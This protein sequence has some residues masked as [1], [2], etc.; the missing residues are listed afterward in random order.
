MNDLIIVGAGGHALVVWEAAVSMSAFNILGFV[1]PSKAGEELAGLPI[2]EHSPGVENFVVA[3]GDNHARKRIFE[4]YLTLGF[5]PATVIHPTAYVALRTEVGAGT[6]LLAK[7]VINPFAT[8]GKNCII[9]TAAT[10]DHQCSIESHVH[11]SV[12]VHLCGNT[13]VG[14]GALMGVGSITRPSITIGAWST[15][16]AGAVMVCDVE[17]NSTVIGV[18]AKPLHRSLASNRR[19]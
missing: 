6:V 14:E 9:N 17:P 18:P 2:F 11:L 7:A 13:T 1:D 16:G 8:V 12:G 4:E 19:T 15:T 3:V 10:V 5:K